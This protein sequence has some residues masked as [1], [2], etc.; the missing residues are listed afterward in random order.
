MLLMASEGLRIARVARNFPDNPLWQFLAYQ[1]DHVAW[2]GC[3][4]W[5]L[6]QPSFTFMVGVALPYS[7][8]SRLAKGEMFPRLF[9]HALWRAF[10]LIFLGVFLR[11]VGKSQTYFTFEDV[12]SQIGLGYPFLFLLAWTK[13][14][15]ARCVYSASPSLVVTWAHLMG[16]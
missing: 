16:W 8:A 9:G 14:K 4:L 3:A 12:L 11:S 6:I 13:P 7:L 1:T 5:D 15:T 10:L 2:R